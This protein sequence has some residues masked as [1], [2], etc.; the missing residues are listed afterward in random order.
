MTDHDDWGWSDIIEV[1]A[2][3]LTS[4]TQDDRQLRTRCIEVERRPLIR[5]PTG[6]TL[7]GVPANEAE[8]VLLLERLSNR[9]PEHFQF[10]RPLDWRTDRGID[11]VV[12]A[13][14]PGTQHRF[15]EFK[16]DLRGGTFNHTFKNIHYVVCWEVAAADGTQLT[17]TARKQMRVKRHLAE[18]Y[19][20]PETAPWTLEGGQRLIKVFALRDI[21]AEK[22]G[23]V[24]VTPG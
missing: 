5:L 10:Y 2:E 22:L 4:E 1:E 18:Q 3:V 17:D 19:D 24:I 15:I 14:E 16:K 20:L 21:L 7:M 8:T 12:E 13:Q 11:S 23:A 9:W 6:E